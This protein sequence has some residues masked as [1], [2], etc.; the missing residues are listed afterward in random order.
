[1]IRVESLVI[2][3]GLEPAKIHLCAIPWKLAPSISVPETIFRNL[4]VLSL[5][6]G[7][8]FVRLSVMSLAV[9]V[10]GC[11]AEPG[12]AG[13]A[14]ERAQLIAGTWRCHA[15]VNGS[16]PE[17]LSEALFSYDL[18]YVTDGDMREAGIAGGK[19]KG[20]KLEL[21]MLQRGKW[22]L[23]GDKLR[24]AYD[25]MGANWLKVDGRIIDHSYVNKQ[26]ADEARRNPSSMTTEQRIIMLDRRELVFEQ[27]HDRQIVTCA[28]ASA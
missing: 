5:E 13:A 19:Y 14:A 3:A 12:G 17:E 22:S 25:Y 10:A 9:L 6:G 8:M 1:M 20:Q 27:K 4:D 24:H 11:G 18:T 7:C 21:N 28:R 15:P 16:M 26:L 23:K 2:P